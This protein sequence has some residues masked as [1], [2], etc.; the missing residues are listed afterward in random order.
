M[1][2]LLRKKLALKR[3]SKRKERRDEG[4][5]GMVLSKIVENKS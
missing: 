2:N 4:K 5:F 3:K 1:A